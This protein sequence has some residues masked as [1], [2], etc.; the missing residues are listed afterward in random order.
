MKPDYSDFAMSKPISAAAEFLF[1]LKTSAFETAYGGK[2][3]LNSSLEVFLGDCEIYPELELL[4]SLIH[5]FSEETY[6][7]M[8]TFAETNS[9]I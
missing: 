5:F 4:K 6:E 1:V 8:K 3:S 9:I 2:S 7:N